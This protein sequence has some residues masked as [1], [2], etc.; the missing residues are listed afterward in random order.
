MD[1]RYKKSKLVILRGLL[2][3]LGGSLLLFAFKLPDMPE[4]WG[5]LAS[6]AGSGMVLYGNYCIIFGLLIFTGH[7]EAE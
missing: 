1:K 2:C 4:F 3:L 6:F 7:Q 5:T